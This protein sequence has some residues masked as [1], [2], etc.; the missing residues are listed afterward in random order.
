MTFGKYSK[1]RNVL[2]AKEMLPTGANIKYGLNKVRSH[3][4]MRENF[5]HFVVKA[6]VAK[7]LLL[8]GYD[9]ITEHELP[10]CK[11]VDVIGV[12]DNDVISYEITDTH[13][14]LGTDS[15]EININKFPKEVRKAFNVLK[16]HMERVVI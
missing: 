14:S 8:R 4:H 11:V 13:A 10:N 6:M 2:M 3:N 15:F 5:K 12:K 16:K 9:V 7:I 1:V